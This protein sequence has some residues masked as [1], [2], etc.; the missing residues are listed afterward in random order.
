METWECEVNKNLA[1]ACVAVAALAGCSPSTEPNQPT[2]TPTTTKTRLRDE[3][4]VEGAVTTYNCRG[5][6]RGTQIAVNDADQTW[7]WKPESLGAPTTL[8]SAVAFLAA[9]KECDNPH[10]N[11]RAAGGGR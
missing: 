11:D 2:P 5:S 7:Q 10:L 3:Y 9:V 1:L 8:S 4:K 6:A